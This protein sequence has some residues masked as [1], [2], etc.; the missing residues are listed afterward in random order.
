METVNSIILFIHVLCGGFALVTGLLAILLRTRIKIHKPIG[1]IFYCAMTGVFLSSIYLAILKMHLFFFLVGFFTYH[2]ALTGYRALNYKQLH[3]GQKVLWVDW[4]IEYVAGTI[5][6]GLVVLAALIFLKYKS[7]DAFIPLVFGLL[8]LNNVIRNLKNFKTKAVQKSYWLQKHI[9]NMCGS[10]IGT[11][12]AF[13]VNMN[14]YWDLPNLVVWLG[15]TLIVAPI[16][17][18]EIRKLKKGRVA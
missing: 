8:G 12:T 18:M 13:I 11:V 17:F 2:A 4:W 7:S 10:Y 6:I 16:I 15:P 14:K 1:F 5:N 3:L 9:G